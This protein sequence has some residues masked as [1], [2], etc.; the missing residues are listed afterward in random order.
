MYEFATV[1]FVAVLIMVI[2]YIMYN[3]KSQRTETFEVVI[4]D[5]KTKDLTRINLEHFFQFV[6]YYQSQDMAANH[7][8]NQRIFSGKLNEEMVRIK[9]NILNLLKLLHFIVT[10]N[11]QDNYYSRFLVIKVG[12]NLEYSQQFPFRRQN[13]DKLVKGNIA[14]QFTFLP[15]ND[16]DRYYPKPSHKSKHQYPLPNTINVHNYYTAE[17]TEINLMV[18]KMLLERSHGQDP[19]NFN[20]IYHPTEHDNFIQEFLVP[21]EMIKR[22]ILY[23]ANTSMYKDYLKTQKNSENYKEI[24]YRVDEYI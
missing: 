3:P 21:L 10:V 1:I 4:G 24:L 14:R 15:S 23:I 2:I 6:E 5:M 12:S 22:S 13:Y 8:N 11:N 18:L 9:N 19:N 17:N 16:Y 20:E 7:D